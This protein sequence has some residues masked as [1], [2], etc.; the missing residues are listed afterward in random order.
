[1]KKLILTLLLLIPSLSFSHSGGTNQGG[2]HMNYATGDYHCHQP[3]Q[4]NPYQTYYCINYSLQQYGPYKT[5]W[6]CQNA[7]NG[8]GLIGAYCSVCY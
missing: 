3:K 1:M 6:T 4:T 2:C 7:I 8:A 5:Y